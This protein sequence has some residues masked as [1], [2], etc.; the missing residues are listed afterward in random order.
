MIWGCVLRVFAGFL[1][2][3]L[4]TVSLITG[5]C[6]GLA[7]TQSRVASGGAVSPSSLTFAS[8]AI[9]TKSGAQRVTVTNAGNAAMGISAIA[10]SGDFSQASS[11]PAVLPVGANCSI[12]IVFAPTAG[13]TRAGTLSLSH[14][15]SSIPHTVALSGTGSSMSSTIS[16][17]PQT[18]DFGRIPAGNASVSQSVAVTNSGSFNLALTAFTASANFSVISAPALPATLL[19]GESKPIQVAFVPA[20]SA[21]SGAVAGSLTVSND[22][23]NGPAVVALSGTAVGLTSAPAITVSPASLDFGAQNIASTTPAQLIKTV[24][25]QN[26]GNADL[27][28]SAIT[29]STPQFLVVSSPA[30]PL[31]IAPGQSANLGVAF[32]P[33]V[34]GPVSATLAISSNAAT[35]P[36]AVSLSGTGVTSGPQLRVTPSS[37]NF[38]NLNLGTT[39]SAQTVTFKNTGTVNVTI[40]AIAA[41]LSQFTLATLPAFPLTLAAG[42]SAAVNVTFAP[43]AAGTL[44]GTLT[45][46]S[47][48]PSSPDSVSLS[49]TGVRPGDGGGVDSYGG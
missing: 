16:L 44:S 1:F 46:L 18:L 10:V 9:N 28:I 22:S 15:G 23:A 40:S 47:N 14:N 38:G 11:C 13:G 45:I 8:Q 21:A 2:G 36:S 26:T 37:L 31:T 19:P 3:I 24:T 27:V 49:G 41:S 29:S 33:T 39:S 43:A 7:G 4:I 12:Q 20:S 25:L 34:A 6:V 30:F 35:S 48:A 5:G 17:A 42:E 32:A